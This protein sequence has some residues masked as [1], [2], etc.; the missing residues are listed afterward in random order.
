MADVVDRAA[1]YVEKELE[2]RIAEARAGAEP[3]T[4]NGPAECEDCEEPIPEARRKAVP[5]CTRCIECQE[6][7]EKS[8][9]RRMP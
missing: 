4:S 9:K 1:G 8:K 7:Y 6:D 3:A 2:Y 5:G